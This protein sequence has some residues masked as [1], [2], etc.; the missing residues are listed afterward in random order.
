MNENDKIDDI[1]IVKSS[2]ARLRANKKFADKTYKKYTM[3]FKIEFYNK[4]LTYC[5][6]NGLTI[7]GFLVGL[8]EK[9]FEDKEN[10]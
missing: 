9:F 10:I 3:N 2:P 5:Q 6:S 7:S 1:K 8:A 4:L